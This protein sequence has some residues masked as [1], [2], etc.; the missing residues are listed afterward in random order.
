M[1]TWL[2]LIVF[3]KKNQLGPNMG[4]H[5]AKWKLEIV[6]PGEL[7]TVP[8]LGIKN[9]LLKQEKKTERRKRETERESRSGQRRARRKKK[10]IQPAQVKAWVSVDLSGTKAQTRNKTRAGPQRQKE[11]EVVVDNKNFWPTLYWQA[12][13][14]SSFPKMYAEHAG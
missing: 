8:L 10:Y 13:S 11:E 14:K 12:K 9:C 3:Q 4:N 6:P 1:R 7:E 5:R 2:Q